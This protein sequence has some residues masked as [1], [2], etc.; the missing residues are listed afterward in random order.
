MNTTLTRTL[1]FK[2]LDSKA[3]E[4]L[5]KYLPYARSRTC[6]Y[7]V[8]GITMWADYFHYEY[9]VADDTLFIKGVAED[10]LKL[11]AFSLPIGKMP[12]NES[13]ALLKEY[14]YETGNKLTLSA[15][16]AEYVDTLMQLG[17]TSAKELTDWADYLYNATDLA[18]LSG[19]AYNK[20]RNHVNRFCADNPGWEL[21][22]ITPDILPQVIEFY[23]KYGQPVVD[24]GYVTA[25][26]EHDQTMNVLR[27]YADYGFEGA[28]LT[29]PTHGIVA[30][31]IGEVAG[32]TLFVHIEKMRHDV[33]G[34]G[35]AI[36]KLF[37]AH[38]LERHGMA[39]INR[40]EDVGDAG[41]RAA[42]LSYKPCM[43]LKKYN[44]EFE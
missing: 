35:E 16:P 23:S 36:N 6:D 9:A 5:R 4:M 20:K 3:I 8:A 42:K 22:E 11:P 37:A 44:I 26:V 33:S 2:K 31:A 7:T 14:C 27:N 19:K 30:F 18:S 29:T 10:N 21:K 24:D 43:L 1:H 13:I 39:F 15:I 32:D 12:L 38:M 40:E 34:A 25:V 41:L 17:A 28:V